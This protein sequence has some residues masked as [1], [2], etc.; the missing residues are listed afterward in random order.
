VG[1]QYRLKAYV[2]ESRDQYVFTTDL[3]M[4]GKEALRR[5]GIRYAR[6]PLALSA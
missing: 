2:T 4:R 1:T 6:V 3:T 5:L